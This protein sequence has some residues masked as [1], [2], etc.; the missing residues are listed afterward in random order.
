[1]CQM[2]WRL[3]RGR[4]Y[5]H[6]ALHKIDVQMKY[7]KTC[8]KNVHV[9]DWCVAQPFHVRSFFQRTCLSFHCKCSVYMIYKRAQYPPFPYAWRIEGRGISGC[10]ALAWNVKCSILE[11]QYAYYCSAFI[12]GLIDFSDSRELVTSWTNSAKERAINAPTVV[13]RR[14]IN[15][16]AAQ[17][18][19]VITDVQ[20]C[21]GRQTERAC[22]VFSVQFG[23][24]RMMEARIEE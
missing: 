10:S 24:L 16:L 6:I 7:R 17:T 8:R 9:N 3:C 15:I 21:G 13:L 1:M 4:R 14:L 23:G 11:I 20:G 12:G 19:S 22:D 5:R 2:R 18:F